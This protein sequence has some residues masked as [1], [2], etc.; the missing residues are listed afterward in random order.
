M[1]LNAVRDSPYC[2]NSVCVYR[3]S[4]VV[5][6]LVKIHVT[7]AKYSIVDRLT[8]QSIGTITKSKEKEESN[9]YFAGNREKRRF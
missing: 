9:K 5:L 7:L 1:I 2:L 8:V 4:Y 3:Q 6:K